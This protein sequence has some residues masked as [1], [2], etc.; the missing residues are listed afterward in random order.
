[1]E[2]DNNQSESKFNAALASL[3]RIDTL[4]Q[5][6]NFYACACKT[7]MND[8]QKIE[9][10]VQWRSHLMQVYKECVAHFKPEEVKD[11]T[12]MFAE[13]E[14]IGSMST[15]KYNEDHEP[16]TVFNIPVFHEHQKYLDKLEIQLRIFAHK[17]KLLIPTADDQRFAMAH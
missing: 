12:D 13:A 1:M 2:F 10:L 7:T 17:H 11:M 8:P 6:C 14:T 15:T 5:L 3:Q 9:N 16:I 4:L